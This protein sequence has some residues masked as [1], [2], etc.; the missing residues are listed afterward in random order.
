MTKFLSDY[1]KKNFEENVN[2]ESANDKIKDLLT[3]YSDFYEEMSHF[4]KLN[5][6]GI[7]VNLTYFEWLKNISL[8]CV[9]TANITLLASNTSTDNRFGN[10]FSDRFIEI[11][12]FIIMIIYL[13]IGGL[14]LLFNSNID[15]KKTHRKLLPKFQRIQKID[16]PFK[17]SLSM[18]GYFRDFF[19][20]LLVNTYVL[21]LS[22]NI[23]FAMLGVYTSK[24]FFSFMLLDIISRSDLLKNVI[25]SVTLNISQFVMTGILGAILIYIFTSLTYFTSM[26]RTTIFVEDQTFSMCSSFPHCF[27]TMLGFG[28]RSGGGIGE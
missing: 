27:L 18:F 21:D 14:W 20:S 9:V 13:V 6:M 22:M 5:A 24:V 17:R 10:S 7:P 1:S 26:K 11:L 4:Q 19:F 3:N 25:R 16:S 23:T 2:R 8:L 28:M 12:G 15:V